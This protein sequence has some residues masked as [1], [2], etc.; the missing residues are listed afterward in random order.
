V[1]GQKERRGLGVH[2]ANWNAWNGAL[3]LLPSLVELQRYA[4]NAPDSG[5]VSFELFFLVCEVDANSE[6]E[7]QLAAL[8]I[9]QY[10]Q[11]RF[12]VRHV[13]SLELVRKRYIMPKLV[14]KGYEPDAALRSW[15]SS[16]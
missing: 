9:A 14:G 12:S 16:R 13:P 15:I 8:V 2:I 5:E 6:F 1:P 3:A 10:P 4:D 7:S 11:A